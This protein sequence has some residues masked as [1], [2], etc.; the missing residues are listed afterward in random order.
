MCDFTERNSSINSKKFNGNTKQLFAWQ[1]S[2]LFGEMCGSILR[3][4][5]Q[6]QLGST[7]ALETTKKVHRRIEFLA[8]MTKNRK[9]WREALKRNFQRLLI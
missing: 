5:I 1:V 6:P 4:S 7:D 3:T 9:H 8:L 2:D